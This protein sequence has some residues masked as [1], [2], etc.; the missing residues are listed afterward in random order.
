MAVKQLKHAIAPVAMPPVFAG[1][2]LN[3][4]PRAHADSSEADSRIQIG[5]NIAPVKLNLKGLNRA[6]VGAGSYIVNGQGDCNGWHTSPDYGPEFS[7]DPTFG[8]QP[9]TGGC[10]LPQPTWAAVHSSLSRRREFTTILRTA[11]ITMWAILSQTG[12]ESCI[13]G[14]P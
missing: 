6:K 2:M 7:K 3:T 8:R 9:G 12:A 11:I 13:P 10:Q 1:M 5:F 14:P 4:S